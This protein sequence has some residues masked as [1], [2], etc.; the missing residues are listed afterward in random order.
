MATSSTSGSGLGGDAGL[1]ERRRRRSGDPRKRDPKAGPDARKARARFGST[2][3]RLF[4]APLVSGD[5]GPCGC[6]CALTDASTFGF[7]AVRFAEEVVKTVLRP[8]QRWLLIHGL[9]LLPDGS[10]RFRNL[11]V[12]VARQNGKSILSVILALFFMYVMETRTV[13]SA[14][15]D[16]DTAREIW[17]DGVSLVTE[18]DDDD[19]PVRPGLRAFHSHTATVNGREA[20]VLTT[21]ERWKVKAANRKAGR[22]LRGDLIILDELRE[23]HNWFAWSA[24]TKTTMARPNAQVWCFSNAGDIASVVLRHLRLKAHRKL[25]DPD[26]ICAA[27]DADSAPTAADVELV[28]EDNPE[29]DGLTVADLEVEVDD[30]FLAEWSAPPGVSIWDRDGWAQSNPSLGYGD[31]TERA[32]ASA[33]GTDPEW[34]FRTE[35]LCQWPDGALA[36]IFDTGTWQATMNRPDEKTGKMAPADILASNDQVDVVAALDVSKDGARTYIAFAGWRADGVAQAE[37]VAAQPGTEWAGPWLMKHAGRI[38]CV[39]GEKESVP[40]S[41]VLATLAKD[42]TFT[43]PVAPIGGT[44]VGRV[45]GRCRGLLRDKAARHNPQPPLDQA[46]ALSVTRPV[47][48]NEVIDL[49]RSP[50]DAAPIRSWEFALYQLTQPAKPVDTP[51]SLPRV[52]AGENTTTT[53]VPSRDF[54]AATVGF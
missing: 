9:E 31:T 18:V 4:T 43:I 23:Q 14:A 26:G 19:H 50:V 7:E 32:I 46:A 1:V 28:V 30:L 39:V 24:I 10:F 44:E 54:D 49:R 34:E 47:G 29:L 6:G 52:L 17:N 13:L 27:E 36:G 35:V 16:L 42:R 2:T 11:V 41:D 15:Q 51:P 38:E 48:S 12:L 37:L 21:G 8:W 25:G 20:L 33:A 53:W 45:H 22:G 3:P 40:A 5:P